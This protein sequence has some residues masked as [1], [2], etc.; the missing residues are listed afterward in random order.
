MDDGE[1]ACQL[2][3]ENLVRPGR[4][5]D[6]GS[7][8]HRDSPHVVAHELD[9]AHMDP[10][11]DVEIVRRGAP[12]NRRRAVDCPR[13][14]VERRDDAVPGRRHLTSLKA[15]ELCADAYEVL[16]EELA[17]AC[18]AELACDLRRVHEIREE[19][20]AQHAAVHA[21]GKAG[22]GTNTRPLDLDE[23]LVAECVAVMS[24]RD[25]EHVVWAERRA[26]AVAEVDS[27]A[28]GDDD[29]DVPRLAPLA[30]HARPVVLRP[31]PSWLGHEQA[32]R[33]IAEL[34]EA[35]GDL[36]KGDHLLRRVEALAR[37]LSHEPGSCQA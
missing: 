29:A 18:V 12:A 14:A 3:D 17:P 4:S 19:Q 34:D 1:G 35:G 5:H 15:L 20:G 30:S 16:G 27:Q 33:E 10:G 21:G 37:H 9:L 6:A 31:A 26:R 13:G 22:P 25:V 7:L 23:R 36:R 2:G 28:S 8:V 24:R 11:S 32:D